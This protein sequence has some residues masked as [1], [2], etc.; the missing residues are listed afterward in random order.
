MNGARAASASSISAAT[1][2]S[3]VAARTASRSPAGESS[4]LRVVR[5]MSWTPSASSRVETAPES[6]GSLIPIAAAASRKC[7][8]SATAAKARSCDRLGCLAADLPDCFGR[9][10]CF[11][12]ATDR[13]LRSS[14]P[15]VAISLINALCAKVD[16]VQPSGNLP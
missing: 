15:S 5:S 6:A 4:T 7:R 1:A 8:C 14:L 3:T 2:S 11:P 16:L 12:W 9:M 10:P 13:H